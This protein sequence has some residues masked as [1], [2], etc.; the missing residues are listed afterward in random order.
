MVKKVVAG[1]P[2]AGIPEENRIPPAGAGKGSTTPGGDKL[3]E[4][5]SED[6]A[7]EHAALSA[8]EE[9]VTAV[10]VE[11]AKAVAASKTHASASKEKSAI[12]NESG[13]LV[14]GMAMKGRG[15]ATLLKKQQCC[16]GS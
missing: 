10:E 8:R 13:T 7:A 4:G 12:G 16:A 2:E 3:Y 5:M 11:A 14:T 9:G 6:E 1:G 15:A